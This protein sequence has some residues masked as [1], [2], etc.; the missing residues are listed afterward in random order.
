MIDEILDRHLR[1]GRSSS[2]RVCIDPGHGGEDPG[3]QAGGFKEKDIVLSYAL[4]L[5]LVLREAGHR[6]LLTRDRD[7]FIPLRR[8]A[9]MANE[10]AADAFVSLHANA[11]RDPA[12]H[13]AWVIHDD[14]TAEEAGIALARSIFRRL[15]EVPGVPDADPEEEV[16]ADA[17]PWVG[18]RELAV[19]SRTRMPAVLVELGFMTNRQDLQE[20]RDASTRSAIIRA[21][22][23]G[24]E[25]WLLTRVLER[26]GNP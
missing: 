22:A 2:R 20:L 4:E 10:W 8:R 12:A 6:T 13:G 5:D 25:S 3:A 19:L 21:I 23:A 7:V 18:G 9:E 1:T 15:A 17:T 11:S 26:E 24:V 14:D 16:Y